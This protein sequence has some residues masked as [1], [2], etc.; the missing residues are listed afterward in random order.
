MHLVLAHV[1]EILMW[2]QVNVKNRH[3]S[4]DNAAYK[5]SLDRLCLGKTDCWASEVRT[6]VLGCQLA[7]EVNMVSLAN[8]QETSCI[9]GSAI[10]V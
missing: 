2:Q 10:A 6:C 9:S 4:N 3:L 1:K 7:T 5:P 8:C